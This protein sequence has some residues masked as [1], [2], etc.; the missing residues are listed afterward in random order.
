MKNKK[1]TFGEFLAERRKAKG[2]TQGELAE[3]LFVG[4]SAVSKWENNK[5]R[6]DIELAKSLAE[7]LGL[8]V[9][10][11]LSASID[12]KRAEEKREARSFRTIRTVYN[13]FWHISFG[14]TILTCF[15]VNLAVSHTLSWFFI[16]LASLMLAFSLLVLPQYIKKEKR[17]RYVPL[18]F[19]ACLVFLLLIIS[20]LSHGDGWI[21]IVT[22]ALILAYSIIFTPLLIKHSNFSKKIKQHNALISVTLDFTLLIFMLG[23]INIYTAIKGTTNTFWLLNTALPLTAIFA[24]PIYLTVFIIKSKMHWAYKTAVQISLWTIVVNLFNPIIGV[25]SR[26]PS[27]NIGY[28][29]RANFH[30]WNSSEAIT[31][32]VYCLVTVVAI[33]LALIFVSIGLWA[34]VKSQKAHKSTKA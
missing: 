2:L 16:V 12:Y 10:E 21:F 26:R 1:L 5:S 20:L 28:F 22:A 32:N 27:T 11:L 25:F 24:I 15:I 18:I 7:I 34:S 6:P 29:W 19:L 4:D 3:K 9:D 23:V 31:N 30:I 33:L 17:L 14:I 13:M 8:S